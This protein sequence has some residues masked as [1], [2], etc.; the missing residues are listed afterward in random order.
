[1]V[2]QWNIAIWGSGRWGSLSIAELLLQAPRGGIPTGNG[3]W[4]LAVEM[5]FPR[6]LAAIWGLGEWGTNEW[7]ALGWSDITEHVR[8]LEWNRGSDE[9][10]GRPRVGQLSLTLSD[11]LGDLDPFSSDL[12]QFYAPGTVI[13]VGLVSGTGITDPDYGRV[14]WL[15]QFTGLIETWRPQYVGAQLA[16]TNS[17][18]RI[19]EVTAAETLRTLA[20]VDELA[21]SPVGAGEEPGDRIGRLLTAAS[22]QYGT[23]IEAQQL[24]SFSYPLQATEMAQNRLAEC[25][26]TADSCDSMFRTLR[27][28]RAGLTSPEYLGISPGGGDADLAAWPQALVSYYVNGDGYRLPKFRLDRVD[29]VNGTETNVAYRLESFS[30]QSQDTELSNNVILSASGVTAQQFR[31]EASIERFGE[32]S[33]VRH[34]YL[35]TTTAAIAQFAQFISIRRGLTALRLEAVTV[36]TWA[37]PLPQFLATVTAEPGNNVVVYPPLTTGTRPYIQGFVASVVHR[38]SPRVAGAAIIWETDIR[39][40]TR[41]VVGIPGA[42]LPSTQP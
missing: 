3:D 27:D 21:V 6:P 10:Y 5:V 7:G 39:V 16:E 14:T 23:L 36:D 12:A 35:N 33:Y 1:M 9:V 24:V 17:S 25:Y 8:G 31:Q 29:A 38:I 32:R 18:D 2:D 41:K 4:R 28:G 13:R 19:I 22:W 15:P 30:G 37:R 26:L 11:P 34:D 42:E 40:D 20:G